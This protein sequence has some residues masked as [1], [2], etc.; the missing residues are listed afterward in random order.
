MIKKK[1]IIFISILSTVAVLISIAAYVIFRGSFINDKTGIVLEEGFHDQAWIFMDNTE[2]SVNDSVTLRIRVPSKSI[3][4]AEISY[5]Y[6]NN[7]ATNIEMEWEKYSDNKQYEYWIGTI[8]PQSEP[9]RYRFNVENKTGKY[10]ILPSGLTDS[11]PFTNGLDFYVMPGFSTPEWSKGTVWY[12]I[13]PVGFFNGDPSNDTRTDAS[14]VSAPWGHKLVSQSDWLGGDL[15]GIEQ[16]TAGYLKEFLGVESIFINPIWETKHNAGYGSHD[17]GMVNAAH[18]TEESL[19]KLSETLHESG[20]R[21]MLDGVFRYINWTNYL[22]NRSNYYPDMGAYQSK[23][24]KYIDWFTFNNW[25]D[26]AVIDWGSP[27][28]DL[29]SEE[30][31]DYIYKTPDS[32]MQRYLREPYSLDGW[33][34]DV[35][36]TLA[37]TDRGE[38]DILKDMRGYVKSANPDAIFLSENASEQDLFD[39]TLDSKWNY[40]FGTS[41]RQWAMGA[42]NQSS[43]MQSLFDGINRLPRGVAL[44]SY[45]F[46]TT[47]DLSRFIYEIG[48]DPKIMKSAQLIQ[49]TYLGSPCIYYGEEIG[50]EGE[51]TLGTSKAAPNSFSSFIWDKT[52]WDHDILNTYRTLTDLRNT[53]PGTLRKG[54]YM[55]LLTDNKNDV[56]AFARFDGEAKIITLINQ[57]SQDISVEIPAVL[58]DSSTND[59]Y[60]D[61]LTGETHKV[62][63]SGLLVVNLKSDNGGTILVNSNTDAEPSFIN[64][65]EVIDIGESSSDRVVYENDK[66]IISGNGYIES[67]EDRYAMISDRVFGNFKYSVKLSDETK[68]TTFIGLRGSDDPS[69][70]LYGIEVDGKNNLT[71]V[72]RKTKGA[73]AER[74]SIGNYENVDKLVILRAGDGLFSVGTEKHDDQN[75]IKI[76]AE[77][78]QYIDLGYEAIAGVSCFD[79]KTVIESISLTDTEEELYDDFDNEFMSGIFNRSS[80]VTAYTESGNLL[81]DGDSTV[82]SK[83]LYHDYTVRAKINVSG[84]ASGIVIAHSN[85]D[86]VGIFRDPLSGTIRF[87][88]N[89]KGQEEI[90]ATTED[91]HTS[92]PIFFQMQKMGNIV[93][94][95]YSYDNSEWKWLGDNVFYGLSESFVGLA[96]SGKQALFDWISFGDV[97]D[98]S[99]GS[100]IKPVTS[101][102]I[103]LDLSDIQETKLN[104]KWETYAGNWE[105]SEG[106]LMQSSD[107]SASL[108]LTGKTFDDIY[109]EVTIKLSDGCRAAGFGFGLAD[110]DLKVFDSEGYFVLL[111]GEKQLRLF[112][113]SELL[114]QAD[115]PD[116]FFIE[117]ALRLSVRSS[118]GTITVRAGLDNIPVINNAGEQSGYFA[119]YSDGAA[120]FGNYKVMRDQ[121][122]ITAYGSWDCDPAYDVL[123]G[124]GKYAS[125]T[126]NGFLFRDVEVTAE[127]EYSQLEEN[128]EY[129]AG[130]ALDCYSGIDPLTKGTI[131]GFNNNGTLKLIVDGDTVDSFENAEN[132]YSAKLRIVYYGNLCSVYLNN[133]GEPVLEYEVGRVSGGSIQ[134]ACVQGTA[135]YSNIEINSLKQGN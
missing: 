21:L 132:M 42:G 54:A 119:F 29:S 50:L 113:G 71:L 130:I 98:S 20:M 46:L 96:S 77:S 92:E 22:I 48:H 94:A 126:I 55:T 28:L 49:M 38:H 34:M 5:S 32:I 11:P 134:F 114:Q 108:G 3:E 1:N 111:D 122:S 118:G 58:L 33:R 85:E 75:E 37:G 79:G 56:I 64:N 121:S 129:F 112:Y 133:G 101:G 106:G 13:M 128:E 91:D 10:T 59:I 100:V 86:R 6:S 30:A 76:I 120:H 66:F 65:K 93:G 18:G 104:G 19:A 4:K 36:D 116:T 125:A 110:A 45:N 127:I 97:I 27:V 102:K 51:P 53:Y 107:E 2:P 9:Y 135:Q 63:K 69:A 68:G 16:K 109:A 8:P 14:V 24:S 131:V 72:Y 80:E 60:A 61:W 124:N 105:T 81:I 57:G 44:S 84:S 15:C 82:L 88:R 89:I 7:Q 47:H 41:M 73:V 99:D 52:K 35:G 67:E 39:Y 40:V 23:D 95:Y 74:K 117:D 26:D 12:S 78:D 17:L 83:P 90:Y 31:C 115:I 62:N 123:I 87:I 25:P 103:D 43:F 70:P